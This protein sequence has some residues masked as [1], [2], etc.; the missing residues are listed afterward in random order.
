M[1]GV[2]GATA[3]A[4]FPQMTLGLTSL[5][6]VPPRLTCPTSCVQCAATRTI[7]LHPRHVPVEPLGSGHGGWS[8]RPG[9]G[10]VRA[11]AKEAGA[12]RMV[13]G[14][15]G[16]A[17]TAREPLPVHLLRCAADRLPRVGPGLVPL[18]APPVYLLSLTIE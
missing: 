18:L 13:L 17:S 15:R 9:R 10:Y 16:L 8:E 2:R 1:N 5:C 14:R 12:H 3:G 6:G 7:R 4:G 11:V